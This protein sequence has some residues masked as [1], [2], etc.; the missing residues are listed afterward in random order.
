MRRPSYPPVTKANTKPAA[1][2]QFLL[3][4]AAELIRCGKDNEAESVLRQ[5]LLKN[6]R[7][8][9]AHAMLGEV[10]AALN[11]HEAAAKEFRN[12]LDTDPENE[13]TMYN[14]ANSF[15]ALG[16]TGEAERLY[17]NAVSKAPGF[18][19]AH[20]NLGCLL[21]QT[22]TTEDA[23]QHIETAA[24]LIPDASVV[25]YHLGLIYLD[26]GRKLPAIQQLTLAA[27]QDHTLLQPVLQIAAELAAKD[28]HIDA[29]ALF[30]ALAAAIPTC[31]EAHSNAAII[32]HG[33]G[34]PL[35]AVKHHQALCTG[36]PHLAECWQNLAITM[37]AGGCREES[38]SAWKQAAKCADASASTWFH[39][40]NA[41]REC[42]D[43]VGAIEAYTKATQL[44]PSNADVLTNLGIELLAMGR[45]QQAEEA[46]T[47]AIVLSPEHSA[48]HTNL[49]ISLLTR[50]DLKA[51][52]AHYEH[53][54]AFP[55]YNPRAYMDYRWNGEPLEGRTLLVWGEQGLGDQIQFSRYLN[56]LKELQGRIVVQCSHGLG[57]VFRKW[58]PHCTIVECDRGDVYGGPDWDV[59]ISMMSLPHTLS[60]GYATLIDPGI[61]GQIDRGVG[62]GP[63]PVS[64][65]SL[66]VGIVWA[67][68][69]H[70][71]NDA[72]RSMHIRTLEPILG[73]RSVRCYSFQK[74]EA[75][76]QLSELDMTTKPYDAD[77]FLTDWI[78]TS[79]C[80]GQLDM[81]LSVDTSV[82]H[83]AGSLGLPTVVLLPPLPDWR[84]LHDGD[85]TTW[86]PTM[87]LIRAAKNREWGTAVAF[88]A[89][90]ISQ[91]ASRKCLHCAENAA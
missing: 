61:P 70:H 34:R 53:R 75:A 24:K 6:P 39:L 91:E 16:E 41:L 3:A 62:T 27:T 49:A 51:G 72:N 30:Q 54:L 78:A 56:L 9:V 7:S 2:F 21:R 43:S 66:N 90:I 45:Y 83:M 89:E 13:L 65:D 82:V 12:A 73:L 50:G 58:Y 20:F 59:Q 64:H 1:S 38:L 25:K 4:K 22:A 44:D 29:L 10:L 46:H 42:G 19:A 63:L 17:R 79:Q 47:R 55:K 68:S 74:G 28:S 67:G 85:T 31:W 36:H 80:L 57:A 33:M 76:A 84:W 86:Y 81:L 37:W 60:A 52:L 88:A 14:L 8:A 69:P 18:G 32:L 71:F 35:E 40:G 48:A 87:R 5:S 26:T 15:A 23:V 77:P 11:R